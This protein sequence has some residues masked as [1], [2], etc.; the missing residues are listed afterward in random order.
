MSL[1]YTRAGEGIKGRGT[2]KE[3]SGDNTDFINF[4][5]KKCVAYVYEHFLSVSQIYT[6]KEQGNDG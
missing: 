4:K 5:Q 2:E 6:P 3:F 1:V